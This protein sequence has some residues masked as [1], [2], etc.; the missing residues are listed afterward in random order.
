M[1]MQYKRII[2]MALA[3]AAV[4]AAPMMFASC[5]P[6]ADK[7][8][9]SS[10]EPDAA[11]TEPITEPVTEPVTTESPE[12]TLSIRVGTYNIKHAADA[13]GDLSVIGN[14]IKESGVAICGVQEVDY[15]TTRSG[16]ADQPALL[17]EAAGMEYYKFTPAIDYQGGK[18][19]TLIL[20]HYPIVD[21]EYIPLYSGGK[22]G[23]AIG[24]AKI[25]VD[26]CI[27]DFFNTHLSYEEKALRT[28][29][30][31]AIRKML[32]KCEH[33]ILTADFNTQ[34]FSE[35]DALGYGAL[36]NNSSHKYATFPKSNSA[37]DN[38]VLSDGFKI[39]RISTVANSHSD[40]RMLWSDL[41]LTYTP[42][43]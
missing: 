11:T 7:G 30:F 6:A 9:V 8:D 19:G 3:I 37:I 23:R 41:K 35:F 39:G 38:I 27:I 43:K 25:N 16:G 36:V 33:Y 29:Q 26:G 28:K 31:G 18:Y 20:S 21:F 14:V 12:R 42:D 32:D 40:H 22:E 5:S 34:D 1:K 2:S 15:M 10:D 24:H 13:G 4:G 17:A